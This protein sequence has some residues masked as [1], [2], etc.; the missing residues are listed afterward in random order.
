MTANHDVI[1]SNHPLCE[2]KNVVKTYK[3]GETVCP[4]DGVS[5]RCEAGDF[6][7]I[8]GPS[9]IGKSTLL[10]LVGGLLQP[11]SG[12]I[13]VDATNLQTINDHDLTILRATKIGFIF[14]ETN[15]F[16]AL[17]VAENLAFPLK[18]INKYTKT[19]LGK[20]DIKQKVDDYLEKLGIEHRR[21]F[22][23]HQLSVGQR[24]RLVVA[25]AL[26]TEPILVLADEPTNDLDDFWAS[27]V[28]K[29]LQPVSARGGAVM[30]VTHNM[31]WAEQAN[32]RYG[33]SHGVLTPK[34]CKQQN[35]GVPI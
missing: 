34:Y 35:L 31:F 28:I 5:L 18:I 20:A 29:L 23:P 10:Y 33:L 9:G 32:C 22:L 30:M 16:Q 25:R 19:R 2:L 17:T 14:Q 27:E 12:E 7:S 6:I 11:D 3:S 15:L 26:I 8:E 24:R 4:V 13:F 1:E 21:D